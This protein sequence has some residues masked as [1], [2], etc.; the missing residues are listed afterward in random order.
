MR[1]PIEIVLAA[2]TIAPVRVQATFVVDSDS[3]APVQGATVKVVSGDG[4]LLSGSVA[5][6]ANGQFF[7]AG[8]RYARG[9]YHSN[10]EWTRHS[11]MA[12]KDNG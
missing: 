10:R 5:T 2:L 1:F 3:G 6:N 8:S 9:L 4:H 7:P 12:C 11:S